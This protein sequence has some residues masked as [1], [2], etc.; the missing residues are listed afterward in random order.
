MKERKLERKEL[1]QRI[2]I[3]DTIN[4]GEFGELVNVTI[5]GLMVITEKEIPT[6][7]IYQLALQL[8]VDIEG[9]N[10]V[11][12][13]ADSLW[14]RNVENFDRYWTGLHI[15]DASDHALKQLDHLITH[16]SK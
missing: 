14:C 9:S 1:N 2:P 16:Y 12:I 11:E 4:G 3:I 10:T 5:E 6:Q 7:S 15:I 13:G 8:P